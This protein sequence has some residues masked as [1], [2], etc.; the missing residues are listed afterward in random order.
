MHHIIWPARTTPPRLKNC[1]LETF[2]ANR[3]FLVYFLSF[4]NVRLLL[5]TYFCR[6]SEITKI[7]LLLVLPKIEFL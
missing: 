3:A 6:F 5:I 4:T 2:A 7:Y 1:Y